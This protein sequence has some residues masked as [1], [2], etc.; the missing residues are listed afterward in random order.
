MAEAVLEV[1]LGNLSSLMQKG[2]GLFLGVDQE[3]R[4][5]S[6]LLTTIK[7]VL[8]DAEEKQLTNTSLQDWLRKLKD[9]A[10]LLDHIL[11]ECLTQDLAMEY[12]GLKVHASCFSSFHPNH[13]LF[14]IKIA[15]EMKEIRERLDEIAEERTKFH[16][17]EIVAQEEYCC[18][19]NENGESN[20]SGRFR[21]ISIHT[22]KPLD[23]PSLQDLLHVNSLKAYINQESNFGP[24]PPPI[25]MKC[26]KLRLLDITCLK[27]LSSSIGHLKHLRYLNLSSGTFKTLPNSICRLWNLQILKLRNCSN[28]Q[29]L[30]KRLKCLKS[31]RHLHLE[32]CRSLSSMAP[33]MRQLT[34]LKTLDTYIVGKQKGFKLAELGQLKLKGSLHIKHLER[35]ESV[36]DAQEA[37]L[38]NKHLK[39]LVLSWGKNE[40]YKLQKNVEQILQVLQPHTQLNTLLVGGY[41]GSQ[42]PQW[43]LDSTLKDL[44]RLELADC[45]NCIQIPPFGKFPSLENLK[46]SNMNHVQF[47]DEESYEVGVA[48]GF[49]ALKFL[50]LEKLPNLEK[51]SKEEGD[52]IFPCLSTLQVSHCP[53]LSLPC[54]PSVTQLYI[55]NECKEALLR[56]IQ[57]LG[58][59]ECLWLIKNK[60]LSSFPDGMLG[61]LTFLKELHIVYH[62]KLEV[63]PTECSSLKAL[64]ELHIVECNNLETLTEEVIQG[65]HSL[66]RLKLCGY[67]KFK[68]SQAFQC[69]T[70]LEDLTIARCPEVEAFPEALQNLVAL[71]SLTLYDLPNLASLP[72]W[73]GNLRLLKSLFISK[74]PKLMSLPTSIRYLSGLNNLG[75]YCCPELQKRCEEETGEDWHNIAH[76]PHT[77]NQSTDH[78]PNGFSYSCYHLEYRDW[79]MLSEDL[80]MLSWEQSLMSSFL[81]IALFTSRLDWSMEHFAY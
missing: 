1:V 58:N 4:R 62:D 23:G 45:E 51:L 68:L 64:E 14:R 67:A 30:P 13:V 81:K 44:C 41:M 52:N 19:T 37:N 78:Q 26:Y 47:I 33:E 27:E 73:L 50:L 12:Q 55:L 63:L 75:I 15:K 22:Y 72:D 7:A 43:M 74:C 35:V 17:T 54:L 24:P 21:H 32:W 42:L 9:A 48:R 3:T 65:L 6:S 79:M 11:D 31:L 46:L 38:A 25:L 71:Q 76:V 5:L 18:I 29:K 80:L 28:L 10:H 49:K 39:E 57:N 77:R 59:L 8:E 69:L 40:E 20:S 16:L 66:K 53:K 2:L 60:E 34:C 36:M 61:G 70:S 56:S